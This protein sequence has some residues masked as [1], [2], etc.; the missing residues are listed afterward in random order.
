MSGIVIK[1]PFHHAAWLIIRYKTLYYTANIVF[2]QIITVIASSLALF[3]TAWQSFNQRRDCRGGKSIRQAKAHSHPA[4][5]PGE[6][7]GNDIKK[8]PGSRNHAGL[9]T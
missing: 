7:T 9:I 1:A 5:I 6:D 2:F 3:Q 8:T 4:V